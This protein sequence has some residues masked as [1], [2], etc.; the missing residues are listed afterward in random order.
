MRD[1]VAQANSEDSDLADLG[2]HGPHLNY[3]GCD[4]SSEEPVWPGSASASQGRRQL[5]ERLSR[6]DICSL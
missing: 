4:L 1:I 2:L 6:R 3:C 5:Q